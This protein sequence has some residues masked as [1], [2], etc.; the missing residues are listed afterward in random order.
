[1]KYLRIARYNGDMNNDN[2]IVIFPRDIDHSAMASCLNDCTIISAGFVN[3]NNDYIDE[4]ICYGEARS[5]NLKSFPKED[6]KLLRIQYWDSWTE[7]LK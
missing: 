2:I 1:M 4:N 7:H 5:L 3:L 6:T